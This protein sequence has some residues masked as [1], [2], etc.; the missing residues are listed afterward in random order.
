MKN[1]DKAIHVRFFEDGGPHVAKSTLSSKTYTYKSSQDIQ[2]GDTVIVRTYDPK[3]GP[4]RFAKVSE[5]G[6]VTSNTAAGGYPL[7]RVL[8]VLDV[9]AVEAEEL[10]EA[11]YEAV[12]KM[13]KRAAAERTQQDLFREVAHTLSDE[14]RA[15]A[16]EVLGINSL[17]FAR[18]TTT[19]VVESTWKFTVLPSASIPA[20]RHHASVNVHATSYETAVIAAEGTLCVDRKHLTAQQL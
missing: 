4:L 19:Q 18:P 9:K 15:L 12:S 11:N 3:N 16:A 2:E 10:A 14:D 7:K 8:Q 1:T 20:H 5:T 6:P 13:L 17:D